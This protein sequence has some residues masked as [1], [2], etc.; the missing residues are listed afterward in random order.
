MLATLYQSS[1]ST[2]SRI[3]IFAPLTDQDMLLATCSRMP[4]DWGN[5]ATCWQ[6]DRLVC[7]VF[8]HRSGEQARETLNLWANQLSLITARGKGVRV[9]DSLFE[10]DFGAACPRG[11]ELTERLAALLLGQ[12]QDRFLD[13]SL[14]EDGLTDWSREVIAHC[15]QILPGHTMTYRELATKAGRP[16]AARAVGNV[17]RRNPW[18]L[19]VPCH[20]VIGSS[21]QLTGYSA[22]DGIAR[23]AR[24]LELERCS[25]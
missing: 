13:I 24:L 1:R 8:G 6:G 4:D 3:L 7:L 18:P 2:P 19:V 23:K 16:R 9:A 10:L 11:D 21:G 25:E 15:R 5:L 20:R 22:P 14:W 17:M 12:S